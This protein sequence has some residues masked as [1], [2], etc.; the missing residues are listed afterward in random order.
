MQIFGDHP[1]LGAAEIK[2]ATAMNVPGSDLDQQVER[3]R[4]VSDSLPTEEISKLWTAF[5][6][7][8]RLSAA[9][10][11]TVLLIESRRPMRTPL[12][13]LARSGDDRGP[14]VLTGNRPLLATVQPVLR[15][16][17][18]R[19][20]ESLA[21][22]GEHLAGG[23]T[24]VVFRGPLGVGPF[25]P[26]AMPSVGDGEVIARL[27]DPAAA[28]IA[29]PAGVWTAQVVVSREGE[30]DR[31]SDEVPFPLA[32]LVTITSPLS[33]KGPDITV[34]L[35]VVPD[36]RAEQHAALLFRDHEVPAPPRT[37]RTHAFSFNLKGLE[38]GKYPVRMRIDDVDSVPIDLTARPPRFAADQT[39]EVR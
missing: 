30:P 25:A 39:V 24:A 31:A 11:T 19:L 7:P 12:L 23:T 1:V 33:V 27:P 26:A 16:P 22:A 20:G 2:S 36:V 13:V 18:V 35:T 14:V 38:P 32:P 17:A 21:L 28:R 37:G 4:I 10:Q 8:Y 9:Y 3:V 6:T 29:W 5:Q 15:T 34:T